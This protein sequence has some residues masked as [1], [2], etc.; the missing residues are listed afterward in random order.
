[1]S[2]CCAGTLHYSEAH[3]SRLSCRGNEVR[4]SHLIK[5]D[6]GVP[7][8][9]FRQD[10]RVS[11]DDTPETGAREGHVQA[12]GVGEKTNALVLIRPVCS[13][14]HD[15]ML[16]INCRSLST[17]FVPVRFC[18]RDLTLGRCSRVSRK[19]STTIL[20]DCARILNDRP[21]ASEQDD[22]FLSP[23]E[24]IHAGHLN[25]GVERRTQGPSSLEVVDQVR[26]LSFVRSHNLRG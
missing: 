22:V 26:P 13:F 7:E 10:A 24:G 23:L 18:P 5:V 20:C 1:M 3:R 15:D 11:D 16:K 6:E 19:R 8:G 25:L 12:A 9:I 2:R 4:T 14:A 21:D 17:R